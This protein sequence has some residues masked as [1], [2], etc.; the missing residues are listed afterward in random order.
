MLI[1]PRLARRTADIPGSLYFVGF[2]GGVLTLSPIGVVAGPLAIGLFVEVATLLSAELN[3]PTGGLA[4]DESIDPT[5]TDT[6]N[7]GDVD[8]DA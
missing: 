7:S 1:R 4:A 2:F 8:G 3:P 6:S 5:A